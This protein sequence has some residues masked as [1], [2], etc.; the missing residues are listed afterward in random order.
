MACKDSEAAAMPYK[1]GDFGELEEALDCLMDWRSIDKFISNV[2]GVRMEIGI[3][4]CQS[5]TD[6]FGE[7]EYLPLKL[8][9]DWGQVYAH[10]ALPMALDFLPRCR[11]LGLIDLGLF[12]DDENFV[13]C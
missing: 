4:K 2:Q 10:H 3:V 13:P 7:Y 11:D 8:V 1:R 9:T 5:S 12:D 6:R